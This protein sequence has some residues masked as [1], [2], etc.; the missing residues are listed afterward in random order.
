MGKLT[1]ENGWTIA[2]VGASAVLGVLALLTVESDGVGW[3]TTEVNVA[4]TVLLLCGIILYYALIARRHLDGMS[5]SWTS[6][7]VL[8]ALSAGIVSLN[9]NLLSVQVIFY[10]LMWSTSRTLRQAVVMTGVG[11]FV[12]GLAAVLGHN[13][14]DWV[15]VGWAIVGA[16]YAFSLAMGL[17]I[18]TIATQGAENARLLDELRQQ[19]DQIAALNRAAG[20]DAERAHLSRDLH[21]TVAQTLTGVVLLSRQTEKQLETLEPSTVRDRS[22]ELIRLVES[23]SAEALTETRAMV[24]TTSSLASAGGSFAETV[25]RLADRFAKET[26]IQVAV[27]CEA[28]ASAALSRA[29]EVVVLRCVQEGLANVRKH[30]RATTV[31]VSLTLGKDSERATESF[32]RLTLTDNGIGLG[33]QPLGG[34][35]PEGDG[36]QFGLA[37]MRD[38]LALVGGA[39]TLANGESATD[40]LRGHG[41]VLTVSLPNV[42]QPTAETEGA[43]E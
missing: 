24:A 22:I 5:G 13:D 26:G 25:Q 36:G 4:A 15:W 12:I 21:D 40:T 28:E 37:G 6:Q 1:Q 11:S 14:P 39:L 7:L 32:V 23:S 10:P 3:L 9:P 18:T 27:E 34:F 35:N 20:A 43:P 41:A 30:A 8:I 2:V 31:K 33:E 19:Q 16:S 42:S 17:W 29:N 38:R